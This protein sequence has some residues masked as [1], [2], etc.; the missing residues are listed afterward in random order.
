MYVFEA[1]WWALALTFNLTGGLAP[2]VNE[3][4]HQQVPHTVATNLFASITLKR[5]FGTEVKIHR[6]IGW[7]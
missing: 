4:I 7:A 5:R 3:R 6:D 1:E 2:E